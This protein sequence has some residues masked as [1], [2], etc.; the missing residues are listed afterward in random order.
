MTAVL[1]PTAVYDD[2]PRLHAGPGAPE[3]WETTDRVTLRCAAVLPV[4]HDIRSFVFE[5]VAAPGEQAGVFSFEPGQ[6]ITLLL[7]IDGMPIS[8]CYTISSPPTRPHRLAITV[9]RV[10]GG[11]V[12]NW[13]HDNMVP[14]TELTVAAPGGAFTFTPPEEGSY[15]DGK[16]LFL[17][18]GSGITP[19]MS[20]TRTLA[21]LGADVDV[22]FVHSARTPADIVFRHELSAHAAL[23]PG[24]TVSHICED[25]HASEVWTG[26]RGRLTPELL[27]ALVPDFR[28][29]TVFTCGPGPYMAGV[30][31]ILTGL[32]FDMANYHEE[33]FVF[34][35]APAVAE[36]SPLPESS[37]L[38]EPSSLPESSPLPEPVE[39]SDDVT[40]PV[41]PADEPS[42]G[43]TV[44]F[45]KLGKSVVCRPDQTILDAALKAG[46][47]VASACGEGMCGTCKSSLL[48][49][50]VD[51]NHNGGI[52]PREIREGKILLCCS[53]PKGDLQ[54]EH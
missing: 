36:P 34:P 27:S 2:E 37:P 29:R 48:C 50:E 20:M 31:D 52:R 13:L 35:A 4:T 47:R 32:G 49:G 53:T 19:L 42:T 11:P 28:E 40:V 26:P 6:F 54:I 45:P 10:P 9:K 15:T 5:P 30:K 33:S 8:R 24:L 23:M 18:A 39:G 17:S 44:D 46:I 41:A 12:S 7:E 14:G 38:P 43:F 3:V 25:D 22:A 51:M 16:Y 21:D 1:E